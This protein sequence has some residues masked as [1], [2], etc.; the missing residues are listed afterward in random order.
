MG[1]FTSFDRALSWIS[2]IDLMAGFGGKYFRKWSIILA[3][4]HFSN[5]DQTSR[6]ISP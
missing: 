3:G 6:S 2:Q 4:N 1:D 5:K